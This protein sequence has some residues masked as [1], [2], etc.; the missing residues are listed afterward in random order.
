MS[1]DLRPPFLTRPAAGTCF[2][3]PLQQQC[4]SINHSTAFFSVYA[5][6]VW[7]VA[8]VTNSPCV[9]TEIFFLIWKVVR[10]SFC[11]RGLLHL[12]TPDK[13]TEQEEKK[14]PTLPRASQFLHKH[15]DA[16]FPCDFQSGHTR[17]T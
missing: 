11:R 10:A 4:G 9:L 2:L 12:V 1:R 16:N 13:L 17:L 15:I 5:W 6:P 14:P 3:C 8:D 7:I